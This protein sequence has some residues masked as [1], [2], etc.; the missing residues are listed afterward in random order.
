MHCSHC[1]ICCTETEMLLSNQDIKRLE[2]KGFHKK[3][4]VKTDKTGYA[5]L[6]NLNGYCVFYDVK[7]QRC[8]VYADR[9]SGCQVYP[10]ILDEAIGIIVDDICPEK[11]SISNEEKAEKGKA[12]IKLLDQIDSEAK[13]RR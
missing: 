8:K 13:D 10:V 7:S 6:K 9:P 5:Q 2:K 4:F 12:V 1:G 11:D 3:F